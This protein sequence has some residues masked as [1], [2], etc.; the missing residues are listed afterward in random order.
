[1][2]VSVFEGLITVWHFPQKMAECVGEPQTFH[3]AFGKKSRCV[4][5]FAINVRV[6]AASCSTMPLP[7][8][9]LK[10]QGWRDPFKAHG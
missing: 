10:K 8:P 4:N 9:R 5:V 2:I 1:M 3:E 6:E 7:N